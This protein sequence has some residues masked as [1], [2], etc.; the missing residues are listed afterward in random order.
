MTIDISNSLIYIEL[1]GFLPDF[2]FFQHTSRMSVMRSLLKSWFLLLLLLP[3]STAVAARPAAAEKGRMYVPGQIIVKFKQEVGKALS[4]RQARSVLALRGI[5]EVR[6]VYPVNRKTDM[7][8]YLS[9]G[10][11]RVVAGQVALSVDVEALA[12][13]LE[14]DPSVEYASPNYLVKADSII[15]NDPMYAQEQH[16]PQVGAAQAWELSTGDTT[17][18]IA[19]LDTGV[20]WDHPDLAG[21]IWRNADEIP[22]NGLDDDGNFY[23]DD[24]MGWDFVSNVGAVWPGE[25]GSVQ[26]NN[27]MDFDGHGTHVAGI[28]SGVTNNGTGIAS[29]AWKC[30]IMP[31]RIGYHSSDGNGYGT[32]EAMSSAFIYAGDNGAHVANLS[33]GTG[34]PI[35][36]AARY[37]YLRGVVICNSAGNSGTDFASI[38]GAQPYALSVAS[39]AADDRK[40]S[41]SSFNASVD[42]S[43]PG[44]DFSGAGGGFLSTFV[45]PSSFYGGALYGE[46]QGTSM[47]SPYVGSLAALIRSLHPAWGPADAMFQILATADSVDAVNPS[48][49]GK[50]G[51]GRI[52]AYRALSETPPPAAPKIAFTSISVTDAGSG[53]S[54]GRLDPGETGKITISLE[55]TWGDLTGGVVTL[56]ASS[57]AANVTSGVW[58]V[59]TLKGIRDI[60][61]MT[62][63]NASAPFTVAIH[64][65]A[66]P[67]II[68]CTITITGD[69]G[70]HIERPLDI[71]VTPSVLFVDDHG[72]GGD[73]SDVAI[74]PY[75]SEA[76][77][78]S[79][80]AYDYWDHAALGTPTP[81]DLAKYSLVVWGCEW[82][83]PSLDANDRTVLGGY[84]ESG[85]RLF[86]SGQDI[87]WDLNDTPASGD[88]EYTRSG[89]V[90]MNWFMTY[91]SSEYLG[92]DAN[93]SALST[94]ISGISGDPIGD[95]LSLDV[96]QPGRAASLQYP[97]VIFPYS[98]GEGVFT[99]DDNQYAAMRSST[100]GRVVYFS[101][102]G[103]ESISNDS[104]RNMV[105]DRVVAWLYQR[106]LSIA[107]VPDTED[108][109]ASI[110]VDASVSTIDSVLSVELYWDTD[111][112]FPFNVVPMNDLGGGHYRGQIPPQNR[113]TEVQYFVRVNT[114]A[115]AIPITFRSFNVGIDH[116]PPRIEFVSSPRNTLSQSGPYTIRIRA[117]DN[118]GIDTSSVFVVFSVDGGAQDS[119]A[120]SPG[121]APGIFEGSFSPA[122]PAHS[123]STVEY[124]VRA[125]DAAISRNASQLPATGAAQFR[126]GIQMVDDFENE[127]QDWD[128]GLAW[129]RVNSVKKNGQ[130]SITDSPGAGQLTPANV[131]SVLT[132]RDS[133]DLRGYANATLYYWRFHSLGSRDT[134]F[135]EDSQDGVIW[136]LLDFTRGTQPA[137]L[138]DSAILQ[139]GGRTFVRFRVRTAPSR[140]GGYD[141]AYVDDVEVRTDAFISGV[142]EGREEVLP[143]SFVL[144]QNYPNPFNP[145][146]TIGF[147]LPQSATVSLA[148][149]NILGQEVARL[150]EGSFM[151]PGTYS[152]DFDASGLASGIYFVRLSDGSRSAARRMLLLR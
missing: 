74:E 127:N 79:N 103:L 106:S 99:Y 136:R 67:M 21:N 1:R 144:H 57:P 84:L 75:F 122:T 69:N 39:V 3:L 76:F 48:Y 23:V 77:R 37:A 142:H 119:V 111:G 32:Y 35:L 68:P 149:Y 147:D 19:V 128:Y 129:G 82:A 7:S 53:N 92:D 100:Y 121:S 91:L 110:T 116:I 118:V 20:D 2:A 47:A 95:G 89:G 70:V 86:L 26:D 115:G 97:D 123:G 104:I 113:T 105:F 14:S 65:S 28:S 49:R 55:N 112:A 18:I 108:S 80:T 38:L 8:A 66:V 125:V 102:G 83:F 12:D 41:Y 16:L 4:S 140:P 93:G 13:M 96:S 85:G 126:I 151:S 31:L 24:V 56:T 5:D 133:L 114:T 50:M 124:V 132:W 73:A 6:E 88:N 72:G 22:D 54:D 101:F 9:V 52:N 135:L 146:T 131:N 152:V 141:G 117:T 78:A 34:E 107:P 138:L 81:Q 148:V 71:S 30:R 94:R 33:F 11:D 137:W 62:A 27:P 10:L 60:D 43:A 63:T 134:L 61:N 87:A 64:P 36:D 143:A 42:I 98:N 17:I 15:P 90:S 58:N 25:D 150:I 139:T 145:G 44:G 46:F 51:A 120:L 40:A 45:N 130:Y 109:T 29:L 59:G